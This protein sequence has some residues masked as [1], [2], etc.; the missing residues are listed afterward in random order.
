MNLDGG[1]STQAYYM[2][3]LAIVPGERRG[4]PMIHYARMIPS[5]G[6]VS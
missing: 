4:L 3:G 5:V 6:V 2:G 1:G